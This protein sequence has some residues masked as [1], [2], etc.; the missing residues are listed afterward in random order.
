MPN[1][2]GLT[3]AAALAAGL[4]PT[5][6]AQTGLTTSDLPVLIGDKPAEKDSKVMPRYEKDKV[7]NLQTFLKFG[8]FEKILF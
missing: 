1:L 8:N 6:L 7:R 3:Q 2:A 4:T 5:L